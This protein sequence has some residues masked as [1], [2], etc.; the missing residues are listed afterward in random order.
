LAIALAISLLG[1]V[2]LRKKNSLPFNEKILTS[3]KYSSYAPYLVALTKVESGNYT[4]NLYKKHN[5]TLGMGCVQRRP[6]T[7]IGC[8]ERIYDGGMSKG[9]YK[10]VNSS[11]EDLILWLDYNKAPT[12]FRSVE[13]FSNWMKSKSYFGVSADQYTKALKTWI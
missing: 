2:V 11:V 13:A 7:Q 12:S 10:S 4:S 8:S 3:S 5:N 1:I 6:T 9:V